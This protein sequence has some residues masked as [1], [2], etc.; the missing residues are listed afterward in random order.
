MRKLKVGVT[1]FLRKGN[2][3]IWENGIYQN[4]FFICRLLMNSPEINEVYLI[5]G[6]DGDHEKNTTFLQNSTTP[7]ISY[8]EALKKIDVVIEL[9]AQ[10]NVLWAEKF[11]RKGGVIIGM[12]VANDFFID[13]ER[14]IHNKKSG[15]LVSGVDYDAVWT[16]PCFENSCRQYYEILLGTEVKAMQHIWSP[17]FIIDRLKKFKSSS[18]SEYINADQI[19]IGIMEPNI[20]MVKTSHLPILICDEVER[21]KPGTIDK[22]YIFN[23]DGI[24]ENLVFNNF[25]KQVDSEEYGI[26]HYQ[27]RSPIFEELGSK[28]DYLVSHH[29][30]NGQNYLY[31]EVLWGGYPLIHNSDF[32][33][34]CG[35]RYKQFDICDGAEQLLKAVTFH[36]KNIDKYNKNSMEFIEKLSPENILNVEAYTSEILRLLS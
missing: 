34:G 18:E 20:C 14:M 10:L 2:Q 19:S 12:H 25:I 16:L 35:Y 26:L 33:D 4:C 8:E 9:S 22:T 32:L 6:G 21:I 23:G 13:A 30:E 27:K 3:S 11:K 36:E 24:K 31:Y 15:M 5:N 1:I 7:I 28:F 17:M 29:L